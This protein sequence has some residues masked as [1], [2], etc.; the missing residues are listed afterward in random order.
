MKPLYVYGVFEATRN[1]EYLHSVWSTLAK[2][3][4][5]R[6]GNLGTLVGSYIFVERLK[7]E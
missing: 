7:V 2:A 3:E 4:K 1:G 5:E 6:T